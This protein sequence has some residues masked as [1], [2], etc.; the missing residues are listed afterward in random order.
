MNTAKAPDSRAQI[1]RRGL[2]ETDG[3]YQIALARR[4][5]TNQHVQPTKLNRGVPERQQVL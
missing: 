5:R 1:G 2:Q 3:F 4:V